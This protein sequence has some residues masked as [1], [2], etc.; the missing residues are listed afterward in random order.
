V[1]RSCYE[2][3]LNKTPDLVGK[4]TVEFDIGE[5]GVVL[6][7]A[8]KINEL[9]NRAVGECLTARLKTWRFPE[10]PTNE[11]VTVAYPFA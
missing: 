5:K 1:I 11:V 3:E 9:G 4:L 10:P 2:R 6:R 8:V 7:A